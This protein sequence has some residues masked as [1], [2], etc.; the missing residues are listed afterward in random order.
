MEVMGPGRISGIQLQKDITAHLLLPC[1]KQEKDLPKVPSLSGWKDPPPLKT[2]LAKM[3][4][5]WPRGWLGT[6]LPSG[7]CAPETAN[8]TQ[9]TQSP[10]SPV[11]Y[12]HHDV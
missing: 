1:M 12:R 2:K 4:P 3:C 10:A 6:L 9:G 7:F 8:P 11:P 5:C